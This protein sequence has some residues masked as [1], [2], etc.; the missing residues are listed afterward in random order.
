MDEQPN[1]H[2]FLDEVSSFSDEVPVSPQRR[3]SNSPA[4][5]GQVVEIA[6]SGSQ[7]RLDSAQ[8]AALSTH[9]DPSMATSGQVGSQ[10]KM[11]VDTT[12]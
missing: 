7:V 11:V 9:A 3:T 4:A 2:E 5:I 6:G 12:G 1:L 10:V 8:L